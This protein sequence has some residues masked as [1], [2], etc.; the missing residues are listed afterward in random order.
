MR[1][2]LLLTPRPVPGKLLPLAGA[3]AVLVLAL[4]V[5]L[6]ADWPIAGWALGVVLW[7]AVRGLSFALGFAR[8]GMGTL[9]SS[10]IQAFELMF[11]ALLVLVVLVALAAT[12]PHL[13]LAAALV[14]ALAYT[15]ELGLSLVTYF[16]STR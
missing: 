3:G 12:K 6:L 16:G 9:A 8:G 11:K 13:A 1:N 7:L 15:L 4:P 10:G 5:F 14:Y 2:S